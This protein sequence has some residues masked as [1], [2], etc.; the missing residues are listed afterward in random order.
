MIA[1]VL[2]D[3]KVVGSYERLHVRIANGKTR[4]H[5]F[6]AC[7]NDAMA[8]YP[9]PSSGE[10]DPLLTGR[11]EP[12]AIAAPYLSTTDSV[13]LRLESRVTLTQ[14]P[15][16]MGPAAPMR[17]ARVVRLANFRVRRGHDSEIVD[18]SHPITIHVRI[19]V[20]VA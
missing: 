18:Y 7:V 19:C 10:I 11:D 14:K 13:I 17:R 4:S 3:S 20:S 8:V 6:G 12:F 5:P 16:A 1:I 9:N 15:V 2:I